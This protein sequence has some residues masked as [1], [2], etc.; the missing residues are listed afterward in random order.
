MIVGQDESVFAQYLLG[1]KTWIGPKGQRPL[2]PKSEGDGCMLSAFVSQEFGFG[3]LLTVNE[4][5]MINEKQHANGATYTDTHV[6]IEIQGIIFK[7]PLTESPFVKYLFIGANNEKHWNSFY[8]SLQLKDVVDCLQVLFP[9]FDLV[10]LFN[11]SQGHARRRDNALSAQHMSKFY[12]K[13]QPGMRETTIMAEERFLGPHLPEL[14]VADTQSKVFTA[15]N[16]GPCY[17]SP[18][19]QAQQRHDRPTGKSKSVERSKK[20]LLEALKEQKSDPSTET[21]L[22][23]KTTSRFCTGQPDWSIQLQGTH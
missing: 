11:H 21:R 12:G 19:Q 17:L 14:Y 20:Q 15:G 3:W 18:D 5:A 7:K 10:F 16:T 9:K 6:A 2:L 23:Q 1:A 4:L 8:M 13:A 22:Y